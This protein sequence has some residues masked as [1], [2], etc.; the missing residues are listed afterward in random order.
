MNIRICPFTAAAIFIPLS[1]AYAVSNS[2]NSPY[3]DNNTVRTLT[4]EEKKAY[5]KA[6]GKIKCVES[7]SKSEIQEAI[8]SKT[9]DTIC[10]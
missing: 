8:N 3:L 5:F 9:L 6:I 2:S 4:T 10:N 7:L 1:F